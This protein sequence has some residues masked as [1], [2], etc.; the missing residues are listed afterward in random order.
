[1]V[2]ATPLAV[3]AQPAGPDSCRLPPRPD[4]F[5]AADSIKVRQALVIANRVVR[6]TLF[7][8]VL[9]ELQDSG[10]VEW[11]GR[12]SRI[13]TPAERADSAAYFLRRYE[14]EGLFRFEQIVPRRWRCEGKKNA[15][16]APGTNRMSLNTRR[17]F[18]TERSH[19]HTIVHERS[20]FFGQIHGNGST[21][22]PTGDG[23]DL[24]YLAGSLAIEVDAYRASGNQPV[25][26]KQTTCPAL[27][28][29]LVARGIMLANPRRRGT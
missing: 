11:E 27:A 10:Q 14:A 20:H 9:A 22:T 7:R 15:S 12:W 3:H 26:W 25:R 24:A 23:C 13:L 2:L 28:R 6:D 29:R 19:A 4:V 16:T 8:V 17:M 21:P 5:S 18:R 1:M